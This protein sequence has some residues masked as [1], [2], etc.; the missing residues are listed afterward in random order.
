M[1]RFN[2]L[3]VPGATIVALQG[4]KE[5]IAASDLQGFYSFPD[6]AGGA[7]KIQVEML[8]FQPITREIEIGPENTAAEWDL[9]M[10]PF[11]EIKTEPAPV[12]F[13]QMELVAPTNN[14]GTSPAAEALPSAAFANLSAEQ[15]SERAA[16]GFLINGSVNNGAA[17]P[18]AQMAAFGNNRRGFKI[19]NGSINTILENSAFNARSFSL[20]GQDT[21]KPGYNRAQLSFNFGGPLKI[22]FLIRNNANFFLSYQRSQNRNA[23]IFTSRMPTEKERSGDLS[24]IRDPL[25][26]PVT[27]LD[28]GTG[29]PFSGNVIPQER[30]S[31]QARSLLNL[32]PLPNFENGGRYNYQTTIVSA[33]H[34]DNIQGT[35]N[36]W[37]GSNQISGNFNYQN[38][39]SDSPN[40]FA[41][42]D[43]TRTSSLNLTAS[44]SRR[45][46]QH[47]S[48][49]LG[50]Q[51]AR[52]TTRTTP[53]FAGRLNI[54]AIA[55]ISGNNQ[56][57]GNW[58]PPNLSFANYERLTDAKA[59]FDR[60]QT[61]SLS[62]AIQVNRGSHNV[63]IGMEY[64]RLQQNL[65][66]QQDASGTFAFTGA[67]AGYDFADFLLGIPDTVSIAFGNPDKYFRASNY[68]IYMNDDFRIRSGFTLNWGIRW[69]YESPMREQYGRLVN[70]DIAPGFKA[71]SP[72]TATIPE[73]RLTGRKYP[74]SLVNPDKR[75]VQPR[76]GFAWRPN[77]ASSWV[78]KGGYGIYRDT[79]VYRSIA[80][81]M[82]QQSPFS[83]SLIAG[84]SPA[85]PL[86]LANG[87]NFSPNITINSF[88]I[89]PDFRVANAQNWQLS[90]QRDFPWST[91]VLVTY[92]GSKG[93]HLIQKSLPNTYPAGAVNSCLTCPSGFVYQS[94]NGES[95]RHAG[96]LQIR[97]RLRHGLAAN[98]R[99]TFSKSI[100]DA[101]LGAIGTVTAQNWL[102]LKAER[103]LSNFDQRHLLEVQTQYTSGSG[104]FRA[105]VLKG[106]VGALM[107]EWTFTGNMT[108]G[109]GMPLTP[110]YVAAVQGTGITGSIRP[111][112][113]EA[114]I[115]AVPAGL[116]LNPAAFS[117]P[118]TGEW[119]NAG[120]N[121]ITGPGQFSLDVSVGRAFRLRDRYNIELRIDSRNTLNHVSFH[122]WNT[123]VNSSQFGLPDRANPMR[124]VQ[125]N[126]RLS[127]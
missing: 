32:Y 72:V 1:V 7:W 38:G 93:S 33:A 76:I 107:K 28:P 83:K 63:S 24:E 34:Q 61:S 112:R 115:D 74:D 108:I 89:D 51:F 111:N 120:R 15:L 22:P 30:I 58:G 12:V 109:S 91:Q 4:D 69:E 13:Q 45:F 94:S 98:V 17:S 18:F 119:G 5:W 41:F 123:I 82:A 106:W 20:T 21:A 54:S 10:L 64:R 95:I 70:I 53:Y 62:P 125:A 116:F 117:P 44:F 19:Y 121:S 85:V 103:A 65:F 9:A 101:A 92:M 39:R 81:Q 52:S 55:G 6:L 99:Y 127:F 46:D 104:G 96:Q 59:S 48:M 78:V 49:R 97:R 84:N 71:V 87:F 80:D 40:V 47:T 57:P 122:S 8:G 100:D 42:L 124:T 26:R 114:S 105:I 23:S 90:V 2:G 16:D 118:T 67:A 126:L 56:E 27:V 35:V 113:T 36:S 50:Y 79:S 86:T 88:A 77:A 11:N 37:R 73:G 110:V 43:K 66:S 3:P 60:E 102:D 68:A 14:T 75:G 25:G 29:N 31:P